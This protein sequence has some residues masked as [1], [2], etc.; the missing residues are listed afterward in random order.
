MRI[1]LADVYL[2]RAFAV[3]DAAS[4]AMMIRSAAVGHLVTSGPAGLDSSL[5]PLLADEELTVLHGHLARAN[6]HGRAMASKGDDGADALVIFAG[7]NA[8]VS[9]AWYPTKAATGEVVPTWNY[10]VV[11]VDGR[12]HVVDDAAF[13]ADVVQRLTGV[14][15]AARTDGAPR[16]S[17]DDAPPDYLSRMHRAIVGI[18]LRV[19]R[20]EAKRKLSQNRPPVDRTAVVEALAAGDD[21]QRPVSRAMAREIER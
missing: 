14:H 15:E 1:R 3:D 13:V 9:P 2:P 18:E 11:H 17:V 12:V 6:L 20:V 16:W 7:P 19:E 21:R 8:Y 4:I 5:L 10:E